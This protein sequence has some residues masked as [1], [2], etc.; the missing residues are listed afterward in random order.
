MTEFDLEIFHVIESSYHTLA[1]QICAGLQQVFLLTL[2]FAS[3]S[4]VE[5]S[6]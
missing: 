6:L 4:H 1:S 2:W 3:T 5:T